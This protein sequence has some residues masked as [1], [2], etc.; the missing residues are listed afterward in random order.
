MSRIE[1]GLCRM[2]ALSLY[3]Y[4]REFRARFGSQMKQLFR[5]R[6]RDT[7]ANPTPPRIAAFLFGVARDWIRTS[8]QERFAAM[9]SISKLAY[10]VASLLAL[11]AMP[12]TVLRAYVISGSS[13]EG[14]LRV[15]DH[16]VVNKLVG[17][18]HQGDLVV[19]RSPEDPGKSF[20]KRIIGLSGDRISIARKQVFRNGQPLLEPYVSH[21][22]G[23]VDARQ[24]DMAET[25]VPEGMM[26]LL[27]DSRDNSLDS[28]F[29]GFVPQENVLG[30]PWFIYWSVDPL[31]HAT[32]WNRTPLLLD[33]IASQN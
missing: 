28:R 21:I 1:R 25:M 17:T 10:A 7:W 27:G 4:P 2:Y 32:R 14:T 29:W 23:H 26:F 6:C 11:L 16:V 24:D 18:L 8:L 5:D 31:T 15:G 3:A 20:I 19:F 13:M 30:H 9:F 12:A 22:P 33:N